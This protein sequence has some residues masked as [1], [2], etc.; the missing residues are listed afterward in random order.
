[1][2]RIPAL[3]FVLFVSLPF[4]IVRV[5]FA[6]L[7][8]ESEMSKSPPPVAAALDEAKTFDFA[9]KLDLDEVNRSNWSLLA[10]IMAGGNP[11]IVAANKKIK[12][13]TGIDLFRDLHD[14]TVAGT[15]DDPHRGVVVLRAV[16][17]QKRI[18]EVLA[19]ATDYKSTTY[20]KYTL[21]HWRHGSRE[22]SASF[23]GKELIVISRAEKNTKRALDL[24]DAQQAQEP[25][26]AKLLPECASKSGFFQ[27]CV[28]N[29]D[30][31]PNAARHPTLAQV[32]S[33]S[34]TLGEREKKTYSVFTTKAI[35]E[36]SAGRLEEVFRGGL[37]LAKLHFHN[38]EVIAQALDAVEIVKAKET[39]TVRWNMPTEEIPTKL[40]PALMRAGKR[41][42]R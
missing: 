40:L 16:L 34:F 15:W 24:L 10:K 19:V 32:E 17:D 2:H 28:T 3:G 6:Q 42:H 31:M 35:S 22:M 1:M 5:G 8:G 29:L 25:V 13:T 11:K 12:E 18:T 33:L 20:G 26:F 38:D 27:L 23:H 37:A 9:F 14:V 36:T 39:V 7:P 30:Q 41:H 21:H 4:L